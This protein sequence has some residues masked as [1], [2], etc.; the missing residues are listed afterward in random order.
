MRRLAHPGV[1][2]PT[3]PPLDS[4]TKL[5]SYDAWQCPNSNPLIRQ[6]LE[7]VQQQIEA[8]AVRAGRS[9][10]SVRLVVVTKAQPLQVVEAAIAAGARILGENYAEEALAKIDAVRTPAAEGLLSSGI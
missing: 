6:R 8:A 4:C 3:V 2:Q 7:T 10:E 5:V 9:P 1:P